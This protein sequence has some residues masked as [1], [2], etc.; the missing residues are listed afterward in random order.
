MSKLFAIISINIF[1]FVSCTQ[2]S[3]DSTIQDEE[4]KSSKNCNSASSKTDTIKIKCVKLAIKVIDENNDIIKDC[5]AKF[6]V[7][8]GS[9]ATDTLYLSPDGESAME[10]SSTTISSVVY[11]FGPGF[12][13]YHRLSNGISNDKTIVFVKEKCKQ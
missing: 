8:G 5:K 2:P 7:E 10:V 11:V 1:L 6:W 9:Y 13:T 4:K 3:R 12:E